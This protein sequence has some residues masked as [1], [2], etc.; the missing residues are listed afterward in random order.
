MSSV[1]TDTLVQPCVIRFDEARADLSDP[2]HCLEPLR[3]VVLQTR[4]DFL[5]CL[6]EL[7]PAIGRPASDFFLARCARHDSYPLL[8]EFLPWL[9]AEALD[10]QDR[11]MTGQA[12]TAWL[13]VYTALTML[14]D[15]IDERRGRALASQSIIIATQLLQRG[16]GHIYA[17][18]VM[19]PQHQQSLNAAFTV[20][21]QAHLDPPRS[22][23]DLWCKT[24]VFT[25]IV[26]TFVALRPTAAVSARKIRRVCRALGTAWQ[27]L[28]DITDFEQDYEAG[29]VTPLLRGIVEPR[30]T[31]LPS[32]LGR[33]ELLS[34]LVMSGVLAYALTV[35]RDSF[36]KARDLLL[37]NPVWRRSTLR[38]FVTQ[39]VATLDDVII[40]VREKCVPGAP[41]QDVEQ[42]LAVVAQGS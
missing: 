7:P 36:A 18:G 4:D 21:A 32:G 41:L 17:L 42:A 28:D 20:T 26:E 10:F 29:N 35:A 33:H 16:L 15:V 23:R 6:R 5:K 1:Q 24:A 2:C 3:S 34:E 38:W 39:N 22:L 30:T 9:V 40:T 14:D 27:G 13:H 19:S 11:G 8:A 12:A 25:G 37:T 31:T